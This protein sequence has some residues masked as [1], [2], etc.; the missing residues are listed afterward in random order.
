[1]RQNHD[2]RGV[3][4]IVGF[5]IAITLF[6]VSFYYVVDSSVQREANTTPAEAANFHQLAA[7]VAGQ[8]FDK[9][10]GWYSGNPCAVVPVMAADG[11]GAVNAAGEPIGRFG[12]GDE[13]CDPTS[14]PSNPGRNNN[15]SYEKFRNIN[16]AKMVA[17]PGNGYVDY[18][19]AHRSLGLVNRG[20]DFHVRSEPV[21]ASVKQILGTAYKDPFLKPLYIGDYVASASTTIVRPSITAA[22]SFQVGSPTNQ[23]S[24]VAVTINNLATPVAPQT[25]VIASGFSVDFSIE[26]DKK[27]ITFTVNSY[28]IQPGQSQTVSATIRRS[29]DWDWGRTG[30]TDNTPQFSYTV[31]DAIGPLKA[32]TH[33]M[34]GDMTDPNPNTNN[35]ITSLSMDRRIYVQPFSNSNKWPQV[36]FDAQ[37]GDGS[38]HQGFGPANAELRVYKVGSPDALVATVTTPAE[39]E[40]LKDE[41]DPNGDG[42]IEA[43]L[44]QYRVELWVRVPTTAAALKQSEGFF[45]IV[46]ASSECNI[47]PGD[48]I[49]QPSVVAEATYVDMVFEKF[50]KGPG[51]VRFSHATLPSVAEGDVLPDVKCAMNSDLPGFLLDSAGNP[52]L[53]K[54]TTLIVGSNVDHNVMTSAAAKKTIR[55]WVFA[56]G[57]LI[58]FGSSQQSVQ[59]LQPIFHA[60][61]D[62]GSTSLY[63]PDP[64]HPA[65]NVPNA[66]DY[67][68]FDAPTDWDY[69]SG[70]DQ[71][72]SHVVSRGDD[73][74]LG[75][76]NSGSFGS[77]KVILSG[78]RPYAIQAGQ[79]AHCSTAPTAEC[80]GLG[81]LHNLVVLSYRNLYLDYGPS[82][83]IFASNGVQ[84]RIASVYHPDLKQ[85]VTVYI[86]VY[87]FESAR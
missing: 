76:S 8:I 16:G 54:Y 56:G 75:I 41:L 72:F 18:E 33:S 61:L 66:L 43:G 1:M 50:E 71:Y 70:S 45:E 59:W 19:E 83:P 53:A 10:T 34:A 9:G 4:A 23:F 26:L 32:G 39:L 67:T 15:L 49:P 21:L 84:T 6:S 80:Q 11:V 52:T 30:H 5:I 31:S 35:A 42:T 68:T 22:P 81:L 58:V 79:P 27:P 77:G 37:T 38:Q 82:V 44:G 85:L 65:L 78:W 36:E 74:V 7:G 13:Y 29:D 63:T 24:T 40:S 12:L 64:D 2:D 47:A 57:T 25:A 62:S 73:D 20:L 69:N 28:T 17:T 51:D 55:D 14:G 60:A 87:V 86:Q 46:S 48:F 3:S